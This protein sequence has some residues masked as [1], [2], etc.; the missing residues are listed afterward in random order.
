M[1]RAQMVYH[2]EEGPQAD[3]KHQAHKPVSSYTGN[4][5][6]KNEYLNASDKILHLGQ[7]V[8]EV[9]RSSVPTSLSSEILLCN[10][11]NETEISVGGTCKGMVTCYYPITEKVVKTF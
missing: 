6:Q 10:N 3:P 11:L 7:R 4:T 8:L 1:H 5:V 9:P 2:G